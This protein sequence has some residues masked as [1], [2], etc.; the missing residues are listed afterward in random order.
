MQAISQVHKTPLL[1]RSGNW[2]APPEV[3]LFPTSRMQLI[4]MGFYGSPVIGETRIDNSEPE[5]PFNDLL[6]VA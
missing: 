3:S 2:I 1:L 5:N 4:S 6:N